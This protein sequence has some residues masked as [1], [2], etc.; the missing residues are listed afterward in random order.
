[1]RRGVVGAFSV[2]ML[3][4]CG[5][6]RADAA[7]KP[8]NIDVV[9]SLTGGG[10]FLGREEHD[11]LV[12][13]EPTFNKSGGIHGRP[14]HFVFHDDQSSPQ[15]GV[16]ITSQILANHPALI[17]GATLVANCNAMQPFVRKG[18]VL[19]CFSPGVHPAAGSYMFTAGVST[20]DQ[21]SA[22]V[23]YFSL[24]GLNKIAL[25]TSTDATGQDADHAFDQLESSGDFKSVNFVS[26]VHFNPTDVNV[27]AQLQTVKEAAPQAFIGWA[28]GSPSATIFRD[29]VQMGLSMPMGTTG[30][31]MT[32][33]Q[34][35]NFA[36]FLPK[37]LYLPAGE[38]PIGNDPKGNLEPAV[39]AKQAE[40]YGAYKAAG[41]TPDEGSVLSW[42]PASL[43]VDALRKLPEGA[44]AQQLHDYL[45]KVTDQAGVSGIYN[46]VKSP[47]RGLSID[48]VIVT[49]WDKA[50][51]RWI[52][53]SKRTGVPLQ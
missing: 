43:V 24:R 27:D 38:W 15:I 1:M 10:A 17:L 20:Y 6:T 46:F 12:L 4:A 3:A 13:A 41:K 9:I 18:P 23:R 5:I 50:A 31:N 22:L 51:D 25:M 34:M 19:Y 7:P 26:R 35:N 39:K 44:T 36:G 32:Y 47:Q 37:D 2:L 33:A 40:F 48:N 52:L 42:D 29:A 11:A 30:G 14:I 45:V 28:T 8:Y 21:A 49:R 53:V 16:Q